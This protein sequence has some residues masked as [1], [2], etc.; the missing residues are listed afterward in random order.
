MNQHENSPP[1]L[2]ASATPEKRM[3][4]QPGMRMLM[5]IGR[6]GW[7]IAAGYLGL[8]AFLIIPAPL[9]LL[10]SIIAIWDIRKSR[11]AEHPKHGMGRALFG[12]IVGILG[13]AGL[14][15]GVVFAM[16]EN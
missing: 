10:V 14:I 8:F 13:S 6:S 12:L 11:S 9:S 3:E 4:D 7:A 5:P 15:L 16:L 1:P 2:P